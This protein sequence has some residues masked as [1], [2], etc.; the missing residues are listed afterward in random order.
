MGERGGAVA[1]DAQDGAAVD[2]SPHLP[3]LAWAFAAFHAALLVAL[4]VAAVFLAGLA[5]NA[6]AGLD[7]S[8]GVLAYLYLWGVA[9]WTNRRTLEA[10]GIGLV[11]DGVD[12]SG[13]FVEGTKWG[14]VAGLLV[15]LPALAAGI[16]L[17]VGAGGLEA[18]PFLLVAAAVGAVV[19]AGVGAAVGGGFALLDLLVVRLAGAWLPVDGTGSGPTRAQR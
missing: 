6:L 1:E 16:V 7:T 14:A 12:P 9:W 3:H 19:A 8:V 4:V 17:F 10:I 11:G 15:F 5:G 13:V 18:V 2:P